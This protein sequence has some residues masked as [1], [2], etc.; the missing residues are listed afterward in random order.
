MK[1]K[2]TITGPRVH[3]VG[4]RYFLMSNAIDLGLEGFHAR[5]RTMGE[6]QEVIALVDGN[7]DAVMDFEKLVEAGKPRQAEVSNVSFEDY[8]GRVM[9]TGEYAQVCTDLRLDKMDMNAVKTNTRPIHKIQEEV[10]GAEAEVQPGLAAQIRELRA[11]MKAVKERL[12]M[13]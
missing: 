8:T 11:D 2:I 6:E 1:L 10:K 7:D 3:K 5:N 9:Q 4:Y 12:G 13:T